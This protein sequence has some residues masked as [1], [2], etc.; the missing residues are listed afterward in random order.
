MQRKDFLRSSLGLVGVSSLVLDACKK[1]AAA[2]SLLASSV[3]EAVDACVV[4]PT[5]T[6]GPYPY[7]GGEVNNPLN[8]IDV[9]EGRP[10]I[11][12]HLTFN[13]VNTNNGCAP[14]QNVRIDIWHCDKDGYYSG[15]SQNGYLGPKNYTGQTFMRGFQVT[16][17]NGQAKFTTIYPGWYPG[18]ITHIHIEAFVNGVV[19][20]ITQVA[21]PDKANRKVYTTNL[22]KAHGQNTSVANNLADMVFANSLAEELLTITGYSA[23]NGVDASYTI[24]LAL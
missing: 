12:L 3:D 16:D 1:D 15:Y 11:P 9:T 14:V 24:G 18:R 10:G 8:R 5:E 4:S 2:D 13:V 19:K 6:E 7:P 22:Y 23:A 17:A 20:K 21:F